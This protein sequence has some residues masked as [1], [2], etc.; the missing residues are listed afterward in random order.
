LDGTCNRN[1]YFAL[2]YTAASK[3]NSNGHGKGEMPVRRRSDR[4]TRIE[5]VAD[6][7]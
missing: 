7:D 2:Q 5:D 3:K 6:V 4:P 1:I